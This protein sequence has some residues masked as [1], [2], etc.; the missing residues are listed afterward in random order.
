MHLWKTNPRKT[1]VRKHVGS[2]SFWEKKSVRRTGSCMARVCYWKSIDVDQC[3]FRRKQLRE[4]II[5]ALESSCKTPQTA[6]NRRLTY[7]TRSENP[8]WSPTSLG[9]RKNKINVSSCK[10]VS[11]SKAILSQR[12]GKYSVKL[13]CV[14]EALVLPSTCLGYFLANIH[15]DSLTLSTLLVHG[16]VNDPWVI[17]SSHSTACREVFGAA[18]LKEISLR[19]K[20]RRNC[21]SKTISSPFS[22]LCIMSGSSIGVS[23]PNSETLTSEKSKKFTVSTGLLEMPVLLNRPSLFLGRLPLWFEWMFVRQV[24]P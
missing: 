20:Q 9:G 4:N 15:A 16:C 2:I 8:F 13:S 7:L 10:G 19:C 1:M 14:G 23:V 21:S 3:N 12:R 5:P 11:W 18:K 17:L 22:K 6:L 24:T